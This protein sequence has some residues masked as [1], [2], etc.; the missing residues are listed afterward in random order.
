[1]LS[2]ANVTVERNGQRIIE[3][4]QLS[5]K[6]GELL[7]LVAPNGSGKTT[8]LEAVAGLLPIDAGAI[9]WAGCRIDGLPAHARARR[10]IRLIPDRNIVFANLSVEENLAV[11]TTKA[12]GRTDP[13]PDIAALARLRLQQKAGALSGGEKRI[14][15]TASAL[16]SGPRLL[17]ADEFSEGL[18]HGVY[19]QMLGHV[20]DLCDSGSI[21][22]LVLHSEALAQSQGIPTVTIRGNRLV[23][24]E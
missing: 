22:I 2:C 21:A 23:R 4:V 9:E 5:L 14:L 11:R 12:D 24:L 10:G 19:E 20:R 18:Q 7:A 1:M 8:F 6:A 16:R 15:A 17:L 3:N 13:L